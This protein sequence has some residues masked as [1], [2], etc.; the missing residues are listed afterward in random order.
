MSKT[1]VP[2]S[3]EE[4]RR[5]AGGSG[6]LGKVPPPQLEE[7]KNFISVEETQPCSML[8]LLYLLHN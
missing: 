2:T 6:E 1:S 5:Q 4:R 8:Y 3:A 7:G